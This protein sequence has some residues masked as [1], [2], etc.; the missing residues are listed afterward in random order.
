VTLAGIPAQV[1]SV[2]ATELLV[3]PGTPFLNA[4]S[5]LSGPAVVTNINSGDTKSGPNFTYMVLITKPTITSVSPASGPPGTTLPITTPAVTRAGRPV[6]RVSAPTASSV[7]VTAPDNNATAPACPAGTAAGT[8]INVGSPVDVTVT[9]SLTTCSASVA[10]TF[11]YQLPCKPGADLSLTKTSSPNPVASG[12]ILTYTMQ[13]NNAG[14][15]AATNVVVLDALP[16]GVPFVSCTTTQGTCGETGGNVNANFGTIN[17][18][19][20]AIL[21]IQ[22]TVNASGGTSI[23]NT[24]VVSSDTP[25]T[26]TSNNQASTTT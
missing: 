16:G 26:N 1:I 2:S 24:A 8:L 23:T 3:L 19:G 15:N 10:G 21:T 11:Q 7:P 9:S 4:C 17:S 12:G 5:D 18:P 20:F 14:P 22:I 25:D 6:P 13:V